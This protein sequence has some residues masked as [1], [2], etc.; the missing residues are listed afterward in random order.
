MSVRTR[1]N[2]ALQP[3]AAPPRSGD[4]S[5]GRLARLS[6][7]RANAQAGLVSDSAVS[8]ALLAAGL[9]RYAPGP[10]TAMLVILA[11]LLI[12]SFIEYCFHRWL[13]HGRIAA[14]EAGHR[15]HH[16]DPAGHDALPFFLPPL[17]MLAL[18]AVLHGLL[19]HG[20]A[21]LLAGAV[22]G[23]YAAYGLAHTAIHSRRFRRPLLARWAALHHIHH[24][25]PE[26][27]FGVT[28][29]LW[30][31]VLGTRYVPARVAAARQG[32]E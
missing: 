1:S 24:H 9:W 31:I 27:N 14:A 17:G 21:L 32:R 29:P 16:A 4:D 10:R 15:K 11:G 8:F 30:D 19:P 28:T 12:F 20:I 2:E 3:V 13:F 18:A 6:T 25:H 5:R 23:G 22:A 7:T 26:R